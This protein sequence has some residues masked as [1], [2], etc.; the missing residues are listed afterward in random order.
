[1]PPNGYLMN[2]V[3]VTANGSEA[4]LVQM[5]PVNCSY[6]FAT[7]TSSAGAKVTSVASASPPVTGTFDVRYGNEAVSGRHVH[8]SIFSDH[9]MYTIV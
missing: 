9:V 2:D 1:M 4:F 5:F 3:E 6:P 7:F 8:F